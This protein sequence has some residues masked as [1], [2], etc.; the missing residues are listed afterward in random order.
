MNVDRV[1]IFGNVD[2]CNELDMKKA[3]GHRLHHR[4]FIRSFRPLCKGFM[5][6]FYYSLHICN[7]A[8]LLIV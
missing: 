5:F 4:Y 3:E 6:G 2:Y 7:I 8:W 1:V